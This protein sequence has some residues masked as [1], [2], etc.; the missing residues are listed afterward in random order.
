VEI[1]PRVYFPISLRVIRE[2]LAAN[3]E[4]GEINTLIYEILS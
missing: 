1:D 3:T 4:A 2:A